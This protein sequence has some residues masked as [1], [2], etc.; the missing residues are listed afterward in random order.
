M[1]AGGL[2][3][4]RRVPWQTAWSVGLAGLALA[5]CGS[6][7][8]KTSASATTTSAAGSTAPAGSTAQSGATSGASSNPAPATGPTSPAKAKFIAQADQ[9]CRAADAG[10]AAPQSKVNAALKAE[11]TK[12][13]A[14]H[15]KALASAVR[16]EA[17]V[18]GAEVTR[19]RA[20]H[21][22]AGD[23]TPA[24]DYIA[25]VASQVQLIEQLAGDVAA[26]DGSA[27]KTVG[28]ELA[29]GKTRVDQL[30]QAYGFKVCGN[31]PT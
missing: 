26:D 29:A 4:G 8:A 6:S 16:A 27:L 25:A 7:G 17:S 23:A 30:A 1:G 28:D 11:Q 5:G 2:T 3:N 24:S 10:L 18:A 12:G 19:L 13:T 31:V 9:V 15:R 22:P 20:L 21:A 14:A